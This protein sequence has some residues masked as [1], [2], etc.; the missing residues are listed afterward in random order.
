MV[1]INAGDVEAFYHSNVGDAN[2][3]LESIKNEDKTT[4]NFSLYKDGIM[5]Q[6]L[7]REPKIAIAQ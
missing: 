3:T 4:V 5:K 1:S 7:I 6:D 2:E